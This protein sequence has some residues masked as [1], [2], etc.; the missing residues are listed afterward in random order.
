MKSA[1]RVLVL[2]P[3]L[4]GALLYGLAGTYLHAFV[5][6]T[7]AMEKTILIGDHVIVSMGSFEPW[8]GALVVHRYPVDPQQTFIKRVVAL[9]G[10][11]VKL[12]NKRL[13]V[14]GA[15]QNEPFAIHITDYTDNYRDNFPAQPTVVVQPPEWADQVAAAAQ[16]GELLVPQGKYFVMGDNRDNSF[17]S[18]YWGFIERKDILGKP[19]FVYLS[20]APA[21]EA[22]PE[23]VRW[24]R[25]F[26]VL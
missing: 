14:N 15:P 12:V 13:I 26:H 11:R 18:R 23:R 9:P 21:E 3:I 6:P 8:R 10:D 20:V 1:L 25:F 2:A 7:G 17:D 5:I 4:A 24:D 19:L 16:Q 22:S